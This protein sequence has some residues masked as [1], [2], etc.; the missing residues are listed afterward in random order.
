MERAV[1]Q[2]ALRA[3]VQ[4]GVRGDK[5]GHIEMSPAVSAVGEVAV[6]LCSVGAWDWGE[7]ERGRVLVK[8]SHS[9][10]L[11]SPQPFTPRWLKSKTLS[12]T[13]LFCP[14]RYMAATH[15]DRW[16][17]CQRR[18]L[19]PSPAPGTQ[20][21]ELLVGTNILLDLPVLIFPM[22]PQLIHHL[23]PGSLQ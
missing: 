21:V 17:P 14:D 10:K 1:T 23:L 13:Q 22:F 4:C 11:S 8:V 12:G 7:R 15:R 3:G 2:R 5:A 20:Q 16:R 9:R 6:E 18:V 19:T